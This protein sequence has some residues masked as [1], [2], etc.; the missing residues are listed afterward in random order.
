M[1]YYIEA[2]TGSVSARFLLIGMIKGVSRKKYLQ[3][4]FQQAQSDVQDL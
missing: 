4:P 1:T 3:L 2:D